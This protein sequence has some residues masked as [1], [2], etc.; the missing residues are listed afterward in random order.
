VQKYN[1]FFI[2]P[3]VFKKNFL[4]IW[5]FKELLPYRKRVQN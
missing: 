1:L 5:L 2:P 4:I 3:N